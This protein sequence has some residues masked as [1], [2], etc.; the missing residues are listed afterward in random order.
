ML[1]CRIIAVGLHACYKPNSWVVDD[2]SDL[3]EINQGMKCE[4]CAR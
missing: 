4:V 2:L 1:L 3:A